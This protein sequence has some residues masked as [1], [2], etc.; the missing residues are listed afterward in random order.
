MS[1]MLILLSAWVALA[2]PLALLIGRSIRTADRRLATVTVRPVPDF[3]PE[4]WTSSA[5]PR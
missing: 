2:V 4:E 5:A 3:V 1:W